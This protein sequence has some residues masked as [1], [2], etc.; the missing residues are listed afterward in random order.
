[1]A[2]VT[3]VTLCSNIDIS[4]LVLGGKPMRLLAAA[5]E[6][7]IEV[8]VSTPIVAEVRRVLQ[9]KFGWSEDRVVEAVETVG[10]ATEPVTATET[11]EA[12]RQAHLATGLAERCGV[13]T[14]RTQKVTS[15]VSTVIGVGQRRA[16]PMRRS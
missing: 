14:P 7:E 8:A 9:A 2:S 11:L 4:A 6:G 16:A 10:V 12:C 15:I 5:I 13:A 1:M 3:R